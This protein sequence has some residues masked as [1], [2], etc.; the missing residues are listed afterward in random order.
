MTWYFHEQ[1]QGRPLL[2]L[3]GIGMSHAAWRPVL[4][5]LARHRRVLAVDLPGF[6]RSPKLATQP[7]AANIVQ[8]LAEQLQAKGIDEPV[9]MVGNSLGGL[10]ALESA[11]QGLARSVVALSPAGLW[12]EEAAS[13]VDPVFSLMRWSLKM[14]PQLSEMLVSIPPLR[15]ALF[16]LPV[17]T[18]AW[19]MPKQDA[20]TAVR[21][22][23]QAHGFEDTYAAVS[24]FVAGHDIDIPLTVAF[25]TRD[26]LLPANSQQRDE[27]PAHTRWL[28]PR[29]WGHVPMWDDPDAVAELIS[30]G[31]R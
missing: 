5:L 11:R 24:R 17:S 10:L 27:L 14:F 6:G 31:T 2:L 15:A 3:H 9:D 30:T 1:G 29:G 13:H 28:Q 23:R 20:I 12:R 22:F 18:Q 7:T 8:A 4:P 21:D 26:W 19:R 16:A 25:G